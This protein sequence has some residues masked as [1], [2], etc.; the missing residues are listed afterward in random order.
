MHI[1]AARPELVNSAAASSRPSGAA[2]PTSAESSVS[3]NGNPPETA[4]STSIN[5]DDFM[6]AWGSDDAAFDIDGS[7]QVDGNDLGQ[8]LAAQSAAVAGDQDLQAL[9]GAW[10]SADPDWDLNADGVVDGIDLGL[11]LQGAGDVSETDESSTVDLTVEGFAQAWGSSDLEYDLNADGIVDGADLGAF[12][13]QDGGEVPDPSTMDRFMASWGSDDPEFDFNGDGIVDGVDLGR[14]LEGESDPIQ[15]QPVDGEERLDRIAGKLVAATMNQFD[16]DGDGMISMGSIGLLGQNSGL[17][18]NSDGMIG[19]DELQEFIRTRL[20]GFS[21]DDGLLDDAGIRNFIAKW[22][23]NVGQGDPIQQSN[24]RRGFGQLS[25]QVDSATLAATSRVEST[26]AGL[27]QTT[28][29]SNL[30]DILG[31]LSLPGTSP[32]AILHQL[33]AKSPLGAVETTG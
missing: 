33:L 11:H 19:R 32:E 3:S 28:V 4:A 24:L 10:G 13:E 18:S 21:N 25:N 20:E 23:H 14:L 16:L 27:G 31:Q 15:R 26:L 22:D 30:G 17:D 1:G 5:I 2:T 12:L 7:G 9:L 8:F 6:A 29:P